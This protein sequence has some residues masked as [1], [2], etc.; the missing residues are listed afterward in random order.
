MQGSTTR[1][2][3]GGIFG[4]ETELPYGQSALNE[5]FAGVSVPGRGPRVVIFSTVVRR[6]RMK[7]VDDVERDPVCKRPDLTLAGLC[8]LAGE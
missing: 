3:G 8:P 5:A 6:G 1:S 4:D 2:W 7:L